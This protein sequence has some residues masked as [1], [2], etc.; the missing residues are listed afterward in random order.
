MFCT[1]I[2]FFA[3]NNWNLSS[4]KLIR[5]RTDVRGSATEHK[6]DNGRQNS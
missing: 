6:I 1:I 5:K 3:E 4:V 2:A